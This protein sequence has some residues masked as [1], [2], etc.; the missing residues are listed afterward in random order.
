MLFDT[1][2]VEIGP[3]MAEIA[4]IAWKLR[5]IAW[6]FVNTRMKFFETWNIE[7]PRRYGS[8]DTS[9]FPNGLNTAE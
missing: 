8:N 5:E 1:Q 3:K 9:G 6:N 2:H 7:C 4:Q